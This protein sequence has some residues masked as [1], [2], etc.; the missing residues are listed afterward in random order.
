MSRSQPSLQRQPVASAPSSDVLR[1][2]AAALLLR[3]SSALERLALAVGPAPPPAWSAG[4][5]AT[6]EFQQEED[7]SGGA[8]YADGVLVGRLD[9]VRRL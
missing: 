2:I 5:G 7:L 1:R 9:G 4:I 8:L 6:I 3:A